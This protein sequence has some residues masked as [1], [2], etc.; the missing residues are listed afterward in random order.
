MVSK[1]FLGKL[2]ARNEAFR[3]MQRQCA[4]RVIKKDYFLE[5]GSKADLTSKMEMVMECSALFGKINAMGI[6][7][8]G[9]VSK[10]FCS[11]ALFPECSISR[12]VGEWAD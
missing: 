8:F 7:S 5:A 12:N 11:E 10:T 1:I 6:G 2:L 4:D 3:G 9:V